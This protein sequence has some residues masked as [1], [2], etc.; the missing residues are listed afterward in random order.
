MNP[1]RIKRTGVVLSVLLTS[2]L[3]AQVN[4]PTLTVSE[5]STSQQTV[6]VTVNESTSGVTVN[7]TTNGT[8]ST[9]S[10]PS[11]TV[12]ATLLIP[13]NA[14]LKV[15]A[16]QSATVTSDLVS[17]QF[18]HNAIVS[19]GTA[20]TLFLKNNGTVYASGDNSAGELGNGTTINSSTPVQVMVNAFR[21]PRF[22][23]SGNKSLTISN[24]RLS[25]KWGSA[26]PCRC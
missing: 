9:Q 19:A 16:F 25:G 1:Q 4:D 20:H 5:T 15:Q 12:P 26:S 23:L 6:S 13:I 18:A 3:R 7:Y 21:S 11:L 22:H 17:T 10:S 14:T 8:I 2:H 24:I